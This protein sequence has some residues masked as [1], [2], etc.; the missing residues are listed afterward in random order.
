MLHDLKCVAFCLIAAAVG[1]D[2]FPRGACSTPSS[3]EQ[4]CVRCVCV[5]VCVCW[6][7]YNIYIY[8]DIYI[9]IYIY[10]YIYMGHSVKSTKMRESCCTH[11]FLFNQLEGGMEE[12]TEGW[13][14]GRTEGGKDGRREGRSVDFF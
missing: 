5:Y 1:T 14:K 7:I 10:I 8:I 11:I 2:V 13:R 3:G 6:C 9:D 4:S 12:G